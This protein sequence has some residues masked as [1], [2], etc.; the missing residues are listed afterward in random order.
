MIFSSLFQDFLDLMLP[1]FDICSILNGISHMKVNLWCFKVATKRIASG[2]WG[3]CS[4]QACIGVDYLLVERN[5]ASTLVLVIFLLL[6]L[7]MYIQ[8]L[9]VLLTPVALYAH[10]FRILD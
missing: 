7:S 10:N 8:L 4:G 3:P 2:K 5:F 1:F 9:S 6:L